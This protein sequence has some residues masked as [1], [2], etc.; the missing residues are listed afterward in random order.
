MALVL[1]EEQRLLKDTARDFLQ[2]H[3]P[4]AALRELRD[5]ADELGYSRKLWLQMAELGWAGIV[6]PEDYGGLDF[7]FLGLGAIIEECGRTLAASPLL[8]TVVLGASAILLGG[9]AQQKQALL[10][11]IAAGELTLALALEESNHH[12]PANT[13]LAAVA[14]ADGWQ[15]S[16]N[17]QFVID[18]H[19]ADLLVV[20]ARTAGSTNSTDGLS[21]FL[22]DPASPG[23]TRQRTIMLDSRNAANI[24]FDNVAINADSILGTVNQGWELLQPVLDRGRIAIAAEMLGGALEVFSRTL[25]YLKEREQFGV[26]IGTF[27]AL[28]HRTAHLFTRLELGKSVVIDALGAIDERPDDLPILASLAKA[29]LNEIYHLASNEAVQM[30]GGIGITDDLEIGFFLKRAR[31]LEQAL[32]NTGYHR[33][34][35]ATLS[36]Y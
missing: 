32:G 17:K 11:Q 14:T 31:V 27:Q 34:R 13:A 5:N 15:L 33:D 2:Q 19:S 26:K 36:G 21:L 12:D 28:K 1:N 22:L 8:S 30:H 9:S 25:D 29:S 24:T 20:V 16:G 18:G 23:V 4:V 6:L 10:P 7:G 3:A 35:Y